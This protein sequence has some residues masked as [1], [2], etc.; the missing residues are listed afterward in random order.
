MTL[1]GRMIRTVS[2]ERGDA[3]D[4]AHHLKRRGLRPRVHTRSVRAEN[5]TVPLYVV[6]CDREKD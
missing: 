6:V 3:D 1:S 4:V 2:I 5:M